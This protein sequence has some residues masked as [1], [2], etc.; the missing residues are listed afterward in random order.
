MAK[1]TPVPNANGF[2]LQWN[3]GLTYND[4]VKKSIEKGE[5]ILC[6]NYFGGKFILDLIYTYSRQS[7]GMAQHHIYIL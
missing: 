3:I 6:Y 4:K 5:N 7:L 1:Q 2:A